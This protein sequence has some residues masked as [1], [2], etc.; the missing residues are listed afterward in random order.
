MDDLN[1][2]FITGLWSTHKVQFDWTAKTQP[3]AVAAAAPR[4]HCA[5]GFII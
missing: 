2:L 1:Q 3:A 4:E 5:A